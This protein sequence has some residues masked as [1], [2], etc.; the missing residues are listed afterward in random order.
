[1][2][3]PK[4]R[5]FT[6][7][8]A[9][10]ACGVLLLLGRQW[11]STSS[12]QVPAA[13]SVTASQVTEPKPETPASTSVEIAPTAAAPPAAAGGTFRGR[14]IDAVTRQPVR[15]FEVRLS[16]VPALDETETPLTRTFRSSSGR[17]EWSD[18]QP[19]RWSATLSAHGYQQFNVAEFAL[20]PGKKAPELVMPLLRGFIVRGRVFDV[21]SSAGI[22]GATVRSVD[23]SAWRDDGTGPHAQSKDDGTFELAGVPGGDIT[24]VAD[25]KD[26]ASREVSM[27]V[28]SET[29]PVDIG[30]GTGGAISGR[31]VTSAGAPI[32]GMVL[33]TGPSSFPYQ[34]TEEGLFAFGQLPAGIYFLSVATPVGSAKE[35]IELAQDERRSEVTLTVL[36]GRTVRGTIRGL[37]PEQLKDA[38]VMVRSSTGRFNSRPDDQGAYTVKGLPSGRALL[39]A[40]AGGRRLLRPIEVPADKDLVFDIVFPAGS[41]LTGRVTQGG[42][43][44]AGKWVSLGSEDL[45]TASYQVRTAPDGQ[46]EI[47]GVPAGDYTLQAEGDVR[48]PI[49]M[50]G[51]A[52]VNIEI[53]LVQLGGRVLED[54][55]AVPVVGAEVFAL[56]LDTATAKVRVS[57]QSD[58]FGGFRLTGL[59][60]GEFQLT[61]Y[62]P[63]YEMYRE[64]IAYSAPITDKTIRL[65]RGGAV[66]VRVQRSDS[67]EPTN[68]ILVMEMVGRALGGQFWVPLDRDG[69]G[70]MPSALSG[71][72]LVIP[73]F[74]DGGVIQIDN[75]DGSPLDL[76]F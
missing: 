35:R 47:E 21:N 4:H 46:Y 59:E 13:A 54:E 67:G 20:V 23:A 6:I 45:K 66:E 8:G 37:R 44:A 26:Y 11:V 10:L 5:W 58:H 31:I 72:T 18:L 19:S 41:R 7:L 40:S 60:T 52:V 62:K 34:T 39:T 1:M 15:E 38:A 63:G 69:I 42:Q 29:Q 70:S 65:R 24:L 28:N 22:A 32:K 12:Q 75:W 61:V 53:P 50:A 73:R 16:R 14:V 27:F 68:G 25:A 48:R 64:K 51:D 30:L 33:L 9:L 43:P 2:D 17:F 74:K 55:G 3:R 71:S 57:R 49:A 56:G 76:K 36:E